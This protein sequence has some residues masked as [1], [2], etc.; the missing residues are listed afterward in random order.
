MSGG[1]ERMNGCVKPR[2]QA[3]K[4]SLSGSWMSE[5]PKHQPKLLSVFWFFFAKK[6]RFL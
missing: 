3:E 5:R 2:R 1:V 6:N 4:T